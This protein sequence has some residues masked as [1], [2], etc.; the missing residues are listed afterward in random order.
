MAERDASLEQCLEDV[1]F[2]IA[3]FEETRK[4]DQTG[5]FDGPLLRLKD[6]RVR[7]EALPVGE[8]SP[9]DRAARFQGTCRAGICR[10]QAPVSKTARFFIVA[11]AQRA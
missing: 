7:L 8:V 11:A 1:D 2:F 6:L 3:R 10:A 5:R 4:N 9:E